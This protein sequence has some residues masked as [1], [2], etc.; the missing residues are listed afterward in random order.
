VPGDQ[1]KTLAFGDELHCMLKVGQHQLPN[2]HVHP[3]DGN[4][5]VF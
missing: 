5:S 1:C 2:Q 4:C 3:E